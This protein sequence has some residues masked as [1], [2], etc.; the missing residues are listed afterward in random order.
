[1]KYLSL[2]LFCFVLAACNVNNEGTTKIDTNDAIKVNA[3]DTAKNNTNDDITVNSSDNAITEISDNKTLE[4]HNAI[5]D[6]QI[7]ELAQVS[8]LTLPISTQD[9]LNIKKFDNGMFN[10]EGDDR[11]T[12]SKVWNDGYI[13]LGLISFND[14]EVFLVTFKNDQYEDIYPNQSF[15]IYSIKIDNEEDYIYPVLSFPLGLLN[16]DFQ[17]SELVKLGIDPNEF[18]DIDFN[19]LG[20]ENIRI[21]DTCMMNFNIATDWHLT[22][23]YSCQNSQADKET[24]EIFKEQFGF[25]YKLVDTD[26]GMNYERVD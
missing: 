26:M 14:E 21:D 19:T 18:A 15:H 4:C 3:N 10:V 9:F 16:Y 5:P 2:T 20:K 11:F 24:I 7:E 22:R 13:P 1:M 17:D 8:C 6:W 12:E 25:E 23:S